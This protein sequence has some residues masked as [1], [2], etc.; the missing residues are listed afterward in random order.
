MRSRPWFALVLFLVS[1]FGASGIGAAATAHSV[2][3]W[4][5]A[6]AKPAWNPPAAVFAPVWTALYILMA[7][8]AW[9]AWR[10][11]ASPVS[12]RAIVSLYAFQL[13]LNALWSVLFFGLRHPGLALIEIILFWIL[14]LALQF[15]LWR[16]DRLAGILW[17]P[18]LAWVTFA[19]SLN[20]GIYR[21]NR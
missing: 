18:Y 21:L 5:P 9:R 7:F 20:A 1:A 19:I 2:H 17:L 13:V 11:A 14:L 8:A 16:L 12:A 6:L 15:R 10:A 3:T 4:Y